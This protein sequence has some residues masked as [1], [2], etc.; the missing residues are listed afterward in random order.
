MVVSTGC[1]VAKSGTDDFTSFNNIIMIG[2]IMYIVAAL[3]IIGWL[4]GYFG[5][6]VGAIIHA[7]LIIGL[8]LILL[9]VIAGKKSL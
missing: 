7:L 3:L 2:N 9:R 6:Q 8:V 5:F 4:I 1:T